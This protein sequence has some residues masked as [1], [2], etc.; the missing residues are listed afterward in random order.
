MF[1]TL[2]GD[3]E[4]LT[5]VLSGAAAGT[6]P[7]YSALYQDDNA[8]SSVVGALTGVTAK[9]VV[10]A[11]D[12]GRLRKVSLLDI[13]NADSAEVA[14]TLAKVSGGTSYP[15][16]NITLPVGARA[17]WTESGLR[18]VDV[19]GTTPA[20]A[21]GAVVAGIGVVASESG[22]GS[23]RKTV[24]TLTDTPITV[25]DALAYAG[26]KLYD[27]PAGRILL[28][29]TTVSLAFGVTT[30]R[31]STIN[32]NAA[33]DFSLGSVTASNVTLAT[34]MLD[35]LPKVDKTLDGAVAA[36]TT[37]VG[38]A[39]AASAQFDGTTTPLDLFLNVSFPTTTDI[40]ADGAL[41]V[42]GTITLHWVQLGDY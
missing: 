10:P 8:F 17:E 21:V 40:D 19:G 2:Y 23:F 7:N 5:A 33:M 9:T 4:Y 16:G 25:T 26:L 13:Y 31:A 14:V 37:A 34:T 6:E 27:F 28:L 3:G 32:D 42:Q 39:L 15:L 12:A 24:L 38:G 20:V 36:Y 22:S 30:T 29:G 11:P 35:I 18:V 1:T 41:K